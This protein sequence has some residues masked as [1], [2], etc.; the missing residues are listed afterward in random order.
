MGKPVVSTDS[1]PLKPFKKM[2]YL[3]ENTEQFVT[4]IQHALEEDHN[5]MIDRI[6]FVK[7]YSWANRIKVYN[8]AIKEILN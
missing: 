2:L 6:E 3:A 4:N 7:Q 1:S 8:N 5:K